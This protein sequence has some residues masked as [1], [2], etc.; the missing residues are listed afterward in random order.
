MIKKAQNKSISICRDQS[1]RNKSNREGEQFT[2]GMHGMKTIVKQDRQVKMK[3]QT[4]QH[5]VNTFFYYIFVISHSTANL[6][7]N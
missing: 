3:G 1:R 7:A 2:H 4:C 5:M 6:Y